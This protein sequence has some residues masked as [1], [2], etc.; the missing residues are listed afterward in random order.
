MIKRIEQL[1]EI[2]TTLGYEY[3]VLDNP[4][5]SDQEYDRYM[6]ELKELEAQHPEAYDPNSPTQRVGGKV[7]DGFQKVEHKRMMLS[8]GNA[9][10][11][12]DLQAFDKR[13]RDEFED[14]EYIV[15]LK[16]DGLAMSLTYENGV[17]KQAV[18]RG[19]GRVGEDVSEN[20]RMIRSVPM[21]I[22]FKDDLELRGE[23]FMPKASFE[24][25]NEEREKA[26]EDLFANPRNAAAGTIRQLNTSIVAKR[27]LDGFWYQLAVDIDVIHT[28]EEALQ[29]FS[30]Q[31]FK[32]NPKWK[33]C[34]SIEGVWDYI[35]EISEQRHQFPY[36]IDGIVV[37]V[38][39]LAQQQQLGTTVKTPRWAIAYKFPAE[40][41]TT[42]LTDIVLTV[43]RTGKI[44]PNAVLEVVRVAGTKVQ[45]A[46]LHNEDF[47]ASKDIRIN[48][49]VVI[50]KAGDIIPE[51]VRSL[52]EQRTSASKVYVFPKTCPIC[53]S[54]LVRYPD[55]AAHYCINIDC[56][57]RVMES[58][59][60]FASRDAMDIDTL[61]DKRVEFLHEQGF[62][63][64]IEDIYRLREHREALLAL[65]GFKETSVDKLL[66]AIEHS[67]EKPLDDL[68]YGLGIK[69]IGKKAAQVLVK[70]FP[71]MEQLQGATMEQLLAIRDIGDSSAISVVEFFKEDKNQKLITCLKNFGLRMNG[72]KIENIETFFSG[73]TVV[74]TGT[75]STMGRNEAKALLEKFGANVSGSV[76][77]KTDILLYGEAAGSKLDKAQALH[78]A[79]MDEQAF[80]KEV[81]KYEN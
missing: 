67:K 12:E 24:Q 78:V 7:L 72:D 35:H 42:K 8:L 60:H 2:L 65:E 33:K 39:Q 57:A 74:I 26:G 56:P 44:T 25:L 9:Y 19:D 61:G 43:G 70:R 10:N 3:Y 6:Q 14:V 73:K 47:I 20:I 75:L 41:V 63:D 71:T 21:Q 30:E 18:T 48:D 27:N 52:P 81:A 22:A 46:Q 23:V 64:T 76:S 59:I 15:E 77:K 32:V 50:R 28:H 53:H 17:F 49:M 34:Q 36:E 31:G 16:I 4:S 54:E 37:K 13:I 55:E 45:A 29:F 80:L 11:F 5:Q 79:V 40:E 1:R 69:H 51:V 68:V 62:L 66:K 58:I 38:N